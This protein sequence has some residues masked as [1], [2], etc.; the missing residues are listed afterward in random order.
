M[1]N[2]RERLLLFPEGYFDLAD[3]AFRSCS[4]LESDFDGPQI[5]PEKGLY[6]FGGRLSF[7]GGYELG[8][9]ETCFQTSKFSLLRDLNYDFRVAGAEVEEFRFDNHGDILQL[10]DPCHLHLRGEPEIYEGDPRL[11]GYS[12]VDMHI[13]E[14]I[15][16]VCK[17]LRG[18]SLPWQ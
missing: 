1:P 14:M 12:L 11:K 16:L 6:V 2:E 9:R 5:Q 4:F 17:F 7:S 3:N 15:G 13:L 10:N 8:F 18:E